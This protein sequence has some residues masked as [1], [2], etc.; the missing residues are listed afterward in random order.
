MRGQ[1]GNTRA[2]GAGA[3]PLTTRLRVAVVGCGAQA[4]LVLIPALKANPCIELVALCD[5]DVRK[6]RHLASLHGVKRYYTDFDR[7]KEDE[8]VQALVLATPNYL[9]APM[10]IAAMEYGKDVLCEMPLALNYH[11]AEQMVAVAERTRRRLMP[12]LVTRLRPDVQTVK[13][14]VDGREL[15][16]VYYCKT[17]WLRGRDSWS[18][19]GWWYEPRRAGGGAFLTLGSALLDSA[20]W[21]LKPAKPVRIYGV[22]AK[23]NA[24]SA[25]EDT[26]FALIRFDSDVVLTVEVGWSLLMERDFVYFNLFGTS[27]A[28]LLN[29]ITINK[30]MHGRLVNITPQIPEKGLL[31]EAYR[32]L[33]E[34]WVDALL[35]DLPPAETVADAL[36]IS[37]IT[38]GFYRSNAS[39]QEVELTEERKAP[40]AGS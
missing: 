34:L 30:E 37:R 19:T 28:A 16:K 22:A 8:E 18:P 39:G 15:G 26:A 2:A 6:L 7:L 13:N 27:G 12:C 29:P 36:T 4:Q 21:V 33:I 5:N 31:R 9:H 11:E 14:F 3:L 40:S 10:A 38:D 23:R 24:R 20:L 35:Q 17:G 1:A 25:V 32:R